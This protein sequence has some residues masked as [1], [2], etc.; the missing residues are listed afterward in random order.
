MLVFDRCLHPL[1]PVLIKA[2]CTKFQVH[3]TAT[4]NLIT[5]PLLLLLTGKHEKAY[6]RYYQSCFTQ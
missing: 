5:P 3:V 6:V 2:G 4:M 1:S